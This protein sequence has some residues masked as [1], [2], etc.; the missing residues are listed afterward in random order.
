MNFEK[1]TIKSFFHQL[2]V[3]HNIVKGIFSFDL[4]QTNV[5]KLTAEN[6]F[7]WILFRLQL[8]R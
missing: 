2:C 7:S 8:M 3:P 6:T 4:D 1:R 5:L